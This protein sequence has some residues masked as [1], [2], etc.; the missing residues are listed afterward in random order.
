MGGNEFFRLK[1][2]EPAIAEFS[3]AIDEAQTAKASPGTDLSVLFSNRA[4][5][6]QS[7]NKGELAMKDAIKITTELAPGWWKGWS[8]RCAAERA[9]GK[10]KEAKSSVEKAIETLEA[11]AKPGAS[12]ENRP[13]FM[14]AVERNGQVL[15]L[16]DELQVVER[17]LKS[18]KMEHLDFSDIQGQLKESLA[19]LS[20]EELHKTAREAGLLELTGMETRD[21]LIKLIV[22]ADA[23]AA[24]EEKARLKKGCCGRCRRGLI[25]VVA[26]EEES[27]G[28]KYLAYRKKRMEKLCNKTNKELKAICKKKE[29]QYDRDWTKEEWAQAIMVKEDEE[30]A[31]PDVQLMKFLKC[32]GGVCVC[33][34]V[35]FVVLVVT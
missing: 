23:F 18:G 26:P 1:K 21:D 27:K 15:K 9:L 16:K 5:C 19:K 2:F 31:D 11:E 24:K 17:E 35:G 3:Q 20:E 7:L 33:A 6:Y 28:E 30:K 25:T 32:F 34:I 13:P 8:R 22:Q 29:I 14:S 12:A 10:L 4:A